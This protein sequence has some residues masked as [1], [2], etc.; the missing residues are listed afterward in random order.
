MSE[1]E[2][3]L[4]SAAGPR[5][6]TKARP[7]SKKHANGALLLA[8]AGGASAT[9]AARKAGVSERTAFRRMQDPEF[10]RSIAQ[11]RDKMVENA[12]G[13][14]AEASVTAV[15]TLRALCAARSETVRLKAARSLLELTMRMREHVDFGARI[16]A[17]ETNAAN[18]T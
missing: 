17:L 2:Q 16:A 5:K 18:A 13:Q 6:A 8:L 3:S 14:L 15:R 1:T 9:E 4:A 10:Q 11:A 12:L 7:H